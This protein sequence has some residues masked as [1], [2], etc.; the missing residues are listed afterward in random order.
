MEPI[1]TISP[2]GATQQAIASRPAPA[3]VTPAVATELPAA[4][5]VT[6]AGSVA[7]ARNDAP[8]LSNP[9]EYQVLV[10]PATHDVIYRTVD[11]RSRQV[12]RQAPDQALLRMRAYAR[13]LAAGTEAHEEA[14]RAPDPH[15]PVRQ[16]ST[17]V[18]RD[19]KIASQS[20]TSE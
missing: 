9:Y 1:R 8:S 3:S 17:P 18:T 5:T 6:A 12:I 2:P 19:P 11:E 7:V 13:S 14:P 10:D 4:M 20:K 15:P 16:N